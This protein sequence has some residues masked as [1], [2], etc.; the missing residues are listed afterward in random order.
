MA[1][2]IFLSNFNFF[3]VELEKEEKDFFQKFSGKV[4][5][6][7]HCIRNKKMF[8]VFNVFLP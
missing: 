6:V 7:I 4:K 5:M 8:V 2:I 3:T 1:K